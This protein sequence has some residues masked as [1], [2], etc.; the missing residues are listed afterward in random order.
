MIMYIFSIIFFSLATMLSSPSKMTASEE[1]MANMLKNHPLLGQAALLGLGNPMYAVQLAQL[2]AAQQ[3]LSQTQHLQQQHL[4]RESD[5]EK[6]E[7]LRKRRHEIEEEESEDA[8]ALNLTK[9]MPRVESPLDLSGAKDQLGKL[10]GGY[11]PTSGLAGMMH[12]GWAGALPFLNPFLASAAAASSSPEALMA[13]YS[14]AA[15]A[16]AAAAA[17]ATTAELRLQQSPPRIS[18]P[19]TSLSRNPLEHMSEIAKTGR[20][21]SKPVAAGGGGVGGARSHHSAWQSQWINRGPENT[22]DI[23]KC[24]TCKNNFSNLQALTVHM[25]E[26][27]HF[28][29]AASSA[30]SPSRTSSSSPRAA[31]FGGVSNLFPTSKPSSISPQDFMRKRSPPTITAAPNPPTLPMPSPRAMQHMDTPPKRDILKEQLPMPRKLVRGQ[32]I[33]LGKGEE[34]TKNILKC[35][36]CGQSF[37]SL[38]SLTVHMQE[39]KHYTKV[40]SKEQITTWKTEGADNKSLPAPPAANPPTSL[41]ARHSANITSVLSCKVCGAQFM[42][43]KALGDHMVANNHYAGAPTAV[44]STADF[45]NRNGFRPNSDLHSSTAVTATATAAKKSKSLPVK[46]LLEIE[47]MQK[48][49]MVDAGMEGK[50]SSPDLHNHHSNRA[51]SPPSSTPERRPDSAKSRS[52]VASSVE[53]GK[54]S[55]KSILGSLEDMVQHN[56]G[57]ANSAAATRPQSSSSHR[58]S[59]NNSPVSPPR[60][61]LASSSPPKSFSVTSLIPGIVNAAAAAAAAA[62]VAPSS[63]SRSTTLNKNP[64]AALQM[65]CDNTEKPGKNGS[66]V[67]KRDHHAPTSM[68]GDPNSILAFSWACNQAVMDDSVFKCPF[69]DTPFVSKGAYRHH[70]SKVHFMKDSVNGVPELKRASPST[71]MGGGGGGGGGSSSSSPKREGEESTEN[72][73]H[74]YAEMAKQLSSSTAAAAAA[75]ATQSATK[76]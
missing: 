31:P 28:H 39:T 47:R 57:S 30:S 75:T 68:M 34:Q 53:D 22:K 36:Y 41:A 8:S 55:T 25:R 49:S 4:K 27:G 48:A 44:N 64:L 63:S 69:C 14:A 23:F 3:L 67:N 33:W 26:T 66:G 17:Q 29:Q 52:S 7:N 54:S 20:S 35:M 72:K 43:L 42:T 24:V 13:R 19:P 1:A 5:S 2:Q 62:P 46:T 76:A 18:T 32:D 51:T 12:P 45:M 37:R 21:S 15:A 60:T 56:F 73:Y 65:F 6:E 59:A 58:G 11:D 61:P 70:L 16:A 38:D 74:K 40:I 9:K 50:N 10:T 71:S